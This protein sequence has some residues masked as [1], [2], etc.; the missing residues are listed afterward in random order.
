MTLTIKRIFTD[1][2]FLV[3]LVL[4][5]LAL[6]L[7][8]VHLADIDLKTI[9]A[10]LSLMVTIAIY[11]KLHLLRYI[12]NVII[13]KCQSMRAIIMVILLFSFFGAMLFTNDVAILTLIPI[14]F[15]IRKQIKLPTIGLVSL[16]TVYAN[17]CSAMTPFGNPQ[18]LYLVSYFHLDILAFLKLSL[19]IGVISL[20]TLFIV[21][22]GFSKAKI[23]AVKTP[24]IAINPT[25]VI[26][27]LVSTLIVLMGVLSV[28]SIWFALVAS[29][30]CA[31]WIKGEIVA[32]VDYGII[33]TFIN[34]FIIVG[35]VSRIPLIH[36]FLAAYMTHNSSV[37][38]TSVGMSQVI[39]NVPAAVLLSKFTNHVAAL[40]LGVTVGGLGTFIASL[41]NLLAL[42]QYQAFALDGTTP[43]F[44]RQFTLINAIYLIIFFRYR[45]AFSDNLIFSS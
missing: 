44:A 7:G 10:L 2:T 35:A 11:E 6:S 28:I 8:T 9:L 16:M 37:F 40:Y 41:A 26:V 45:I 12:A 21:L 23:A 33:L 30:A 17:L 19:P 5:V 31:F 22:F 3:T 39:S 18:N 34:F 24:H 25:Q 42:R 43:K 4:A 13:E 14:V 32:E 36:D 1:K 27:L 38:A 20:A 29:L 15:N